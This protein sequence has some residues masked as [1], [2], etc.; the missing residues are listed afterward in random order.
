MA[1]ASGAGF[2]P[3]EAAVLTGL[4]PK[5][6]NK[7]IDTGAITPSDARARPRLL[8]PEQLVF[9]RL[10]RSLAKLM[11]LQ[12]RRAIF[13]ELRRNRRARA[14]RQGDAVVIDV[15]QARRH[16]ATALRELRRARRA[17]VADPGVMGG[18]P[19]FRGTRIPVHAV[20]EMV[21]QGADD[22]ELLAGYPSLTPE[23]IRSATL[24]ARAWPR[25]G[26]PRAQPWH[27]RRAVK[28]SAF[29]LDGLGT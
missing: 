10:E 15:A 4:T 13:A 18:E 22:A 25:R 2:T 24:Y 19:V 26:R 27:G 29:D 17:V 9:L 23:L 3:T 16:V 8:S 12:V 6:V 21:D 5:A 28:R 14:L 1:W 11:P 7:A 20:A